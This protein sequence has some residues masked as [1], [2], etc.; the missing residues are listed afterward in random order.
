M[1]GTEGY[2]H[3]TPKQSQRQVN[4]TDRASIEPKFGTSLSGYL[5]ENV[6][7]VVLSWRK[8]TITNWILYLKQSASVRPVLNVVVGKDVETPAFHSNVGAP[9][10]A[11]G[12]PW[13]W[14]FPVT[15]IMKKRYLLWAHQK[16]MRRK[17]GFWVHMAVPCGIVFEIYL[18]NLNK[19]PLLAVAPSP[20]SANEVAKAYCIRDMKRKVNDEKQAHL[21]WRETDAAKATVPMD[22]WWLSWRHMLW[23]RRDSIV[24]SLNQRFLR[25]PL[26]KRRLDRHR[27]PLTSLE[28]HIYDA[29]AAESQK[30][31]ICLLVIKLAVSISAYLVSTFSYC[32]DVKWKAWE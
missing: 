21:E 1:L 7:K 2:G 14:C 32:H 15:I 13:F 18:R 20:S 31:G 4:E 17:R 28:N 10:L 16:M 6:R 9:F 19:D 26:R 30:K 25:N 12:P 5:D 22:Q 29:S 3:E 8:C 23:A 24:P 27:H 11:T